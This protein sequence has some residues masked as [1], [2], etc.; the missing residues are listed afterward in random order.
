MYA[1]IISNYTPATP[2]RQKRTVLRWEKKRRWQGSCL[3]CKHYSYACYSCREKYVSLIFFN[4]T[5]SSD[6]YLISTEDSRLNTTPPA[7][8]NEDLRV[9]FLWPHNF[10]DTSSL[11]LT[12]DFVFLSKSSLTVCT[13]GTFNYRTLIR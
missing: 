11:F 4:K 13:F 10:P 7:A 2:A 12:Y 9:Y 6:S 1:G 8:N 3:T 5:E